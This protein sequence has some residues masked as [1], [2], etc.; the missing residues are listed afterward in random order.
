MLKYF[1][2]SG[3][4][5]MV[6]FDPET[7]TIDAVDYLRTNID[8]AYY[9]PEDGVL[10]M[11]GTEKAVKKGDI[12]LKFYPT[13]EFSTNPCVVVRNKEWKQNINA[14][15]DYIAKRKAEKTSEP[16]CDDCKC[17]EASC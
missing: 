16:C 3:V 6:A 10:T 13:R 1:L 5:Q 12:V 17:C 9:V 2:K 7:E 8:W 14:E 4:S 15:R 11:D